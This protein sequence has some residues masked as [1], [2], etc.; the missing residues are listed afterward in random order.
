MASRLQGSDAASIESCR[1]ETA[2]TAQPPQRKESSPL[3]GE[4]L[5]AA[6]KGYSSQVERLLREG[7]GAAAAVTDKVGLPATVRSR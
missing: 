7:G 3:T 6:R 5:V 1:K 4:L 2:P